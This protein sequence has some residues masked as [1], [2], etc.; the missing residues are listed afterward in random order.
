MNYAGE[1]LRSYI[2]TYGIAE[3]KNNQALIGYI[4]DICPREKKFINCL[5]MACNN[6]LISPLSGTITCTE[7]Q[8]QM[9]INNIHARLMSDVGLSSDVADDF[10]QSLA[11]GLKWSCTIPRAN[12]SGN[13]E[14]NKVR[15]TPELNVKRYPTNIHNQHGQ[16]QQPP[17]QKQQS[18]DA[19]I[20]KQQLDS[21]YMRRENLKSQLNSIKRFS[22]NVALLASFIILS[23]CVICAAAFFSLNSSISNPAALGIVWIALVIDIIL[24]HK[25]RKGYCVDPSC[26]MSY[27]M[28]CYIIPWIYVVIMYIRANTNKDYDAQRNQI[29]QEISDISADIDRLENAR[30]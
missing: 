5:T 17:Q 3:L 27:F 12:S 8:Q 9:M 4:K 7:I 2:S 13:T 23:V 19:N 10:I 16:T 6:G 25:L 18:L 1:A 11:Y 15:N 28:F 26:I 29:L 24:L 22:G 14:S 30:Y 21:L 20:K